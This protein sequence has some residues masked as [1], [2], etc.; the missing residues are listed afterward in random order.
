LI[1]VCCKVEVS[2]KGPIT[3]SE[4]SPTDCDMSLYMIYIPKEWGGPGSRWAVAPEGGGV[5]TFIQNM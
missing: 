4:R 5:I 3:R 2:V 1:D